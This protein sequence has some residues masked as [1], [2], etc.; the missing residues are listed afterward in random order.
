MASWIKSL[1]GGSAELNEL[2]ELPKD[3]KQIFEQA[4]RDRKAL[5]DLLRRSEKAQ[6][7]LQD[8]S[9]PLA[10]VQASAESMKLQID[11]L[12]AR[13]DSFTDVSQQVDSVELRAV[14]LTESQSKAATTLDDAS[15]RVSDLKVQVREIRSMVDEIVTARDDL[16]EMAGPYG[17]VATLLKRVNVLREELQGMQ[18]RGAQL[19][20]TAEKLEVFE[21]K[22]GEIQSSHEELAGTVTRTTNSANRLEGRVTELQVEVEK[23]SDARAVMSELLGPNGGLSVVQ[24][25]FGKVKDELSRIEG[26]TLTL[27]KLEARVQDIARQADSVAANQQTALSAIQ[28]SSGEVKDLDAKI[29]D[30]RSGVESVAVARQEIADLSGPNGAL[31]KLRAKMEEARKQ[32]L[33]YSEDVARIREDQSDAR[34]SQEAILSRYVELRGSMDNLDKAVEQATN[35]V[36]SVETTM[37]DLAKA[38]ELASR[39]ERQLNAL[40]G[41][42]DHVSQK[43]AALERQ[44]EAID[45]TEA[46]A[47]ALTDLH[48]ELETKLKE[49]K[50]QVK[51][52]KKVNAS[53]ESLRTLHAQVAEQSEELRAGQARIRTEDKELQNTLANLREEVRTSTQS[54]ELGQANLEAIDQ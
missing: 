14:A 7:A 30:L 31:A 54:F 34:G 26:R 5:R 16:T 37:Q 45:R 27:G 48:W 47:R 38:D 42:S 24:K 35:R 10:S 32:S 39:T 29:V 17:T 46:Q 53:V 52:V 41:L 11:E 8:V 15:K 23:V 50:G 44:R 13:I 36:A 19:K 28:T 25:E 51:E 40:R 9:A 33:D 43:T 3:L 2:T 12:Q 21:G 18:D 1:F 49:A 22:M 4:K 20:N 6:Q